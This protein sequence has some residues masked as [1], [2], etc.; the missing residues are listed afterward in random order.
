M[1]RRQDYH[2]SA[3]IVADGP[4]AGEMLKAVGALCPDGVRRT[5][6]P[7]WD[8]VADTFFSIPARVSAKGTTVSGYVT[9]ETVGGSSIPTDDDPL[10][11]KFKPYKYRQNHH[12]VEPVDEEV[13]A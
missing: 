3:L 2:E 4:F 12:L 11:V 10:T 8:G 13:A 5:A 1:A 6:R 7:S 9:I